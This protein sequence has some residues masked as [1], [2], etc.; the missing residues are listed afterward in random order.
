M[1]VADDVVVVSSHAKIVGTSRAHSSFCDG[2]MVCSF[3]FG[4]W[5]RQGFFVVATVNNMS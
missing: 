3:G 4:E 2:C 1:D 5:E